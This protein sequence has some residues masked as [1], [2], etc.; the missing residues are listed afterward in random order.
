M[1]THLTGHGRG[2]RAAASAL[3]LLT[4]MLVA[5][6]EQ[7]AWEAGG[8]DGPDGTATH[9]PSAECAG[10]PDEA[11]SAMPTRV[12]A[13]CG[14]VRAVASLVIDSGGGPELCVGG[15]AY[16]YP[17]QCGGP[18]LVGWSWDAVES[19][20]SGDVRFSRGAVL[21]TGTFDGATF[22]LTGVSPEE[23]PDL[24]AWPELAA[25]SGRDRD[26]ED[27]EEDEFTTPCATPAGGWVAAEPARSG[28]EHQDAA[29]QAA[30]ALDGHVDTWVDLPQGASARRLGETETVLN[31]ATHADPDAVRRTVR[32][33][34]GG[35][36][37]VSTSDVD[38]TAG[39]L[40]QIQDAVT[41]L[42][43]LLE[44]SSDNRAGRVDV[45]VLHDDGSLQAWCDSTYGV[46]RVRVTSALMPLVGG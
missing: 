21:V 39:E 7:V 17:P 10:V 40:E 26:V 31:L 23:E 18:E 25:G 5:C 19:E 43:G 46:G 42:P 3:L 35:A 29:I 33:H 27:D 13:A 4:P 22:V 36:L 16:S 11:P 38:I 41:D 37:C 20:K 24:D 34:W 8:T 6:G 44:A 15:V 2:R 1:G 45:V 14:E 9:R 32:Q 28:Y 12:P 30:E